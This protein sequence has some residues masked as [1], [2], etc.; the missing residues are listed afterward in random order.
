MGR[1]GHCI[2]GSLCALPVFRNSMNRFSWLR[3]FAL[4]YWCRLW[5]AAAFEHD[6]AIAVC[7]GGRSSVTRFSANLNVVTGSTCGTLAPPRVWAVNRFFHV[8]GVVQAISASP[9]VCFHW[10]VTLPMNDTFCLCV[11]T[12]VSGRIDRFDVQAEGHA[13]PESFAECPVLSPTATC[14]F[15]NVEVGRSI[16]FL[17]AR[18]R[19]VRA[20]NL[21]RTYLSFTPVDLFVKRLSG[22]LLKW[23][24]SRLLVFVDLV[25]DRVFYHFETESL[26]PVFN[27]IVAGSSLDREKA[28][29]SNRLPPFTDQLACMGFKRFHVWPKGRGRIAREVLAGVPYVRDASDGP[30]PR[31]QR[32]S[33]VNLPV[34]KRL[35]RDC[36]LTRGV[37]GI[38]ACT[39]VLFLNRERGRRVITNM[40]Q[41]VAS[42]R[43]EARSLRLCFE[44]RVTSFDRLAFSKQY[45]EV[46]RADVLVTIHGSA[47]THVLFMKPNSLLVEILPYQYHK[48][49]TYG[50]LARCAGL[51]YEMFC[52]SRSS[53][54]PMSSV[55]RDEV[56]RNEKLLVSSFRHRYNQRQQSVTL[57]GNETN[58][59]ARIVVSWL[60]GKTAGGRADCGICPCREYTPEMSSLP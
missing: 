11:Q 57:N 60:S 49:F 9:C 33:L 23:D 17:C 54:L 10:S 21:S 2:C 55:L 16:G 7:L 26:I 20:L 39:R 40:K 32:Y 12:P 31:C 25:W 28:L 59:V 24:S 13:G 5:S 51:N 19:L 27:M 41:L 30:K 29:L 50:P 47:E 37:Q 44:D 45:N 34:W 35:H 4:C 42:F 46:V 18:C 53:S 3:L 43:R 36:L 58:E 14:R 56:D 52:A 22:R 6:F 1:V 15:F 48:F 38:N 8:Q